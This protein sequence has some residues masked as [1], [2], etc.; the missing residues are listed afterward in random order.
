M[1]IFE[2]MDQAETS[3][4]D[5]GQGVIYFLTRKGEIVYVGKSTIYASPGRIQWHKGKSRK[6]FDSFYI[7]PVLLQNEELFKL[8]AGLICLINPEYNKDKTKVNFLNVQYAMEQIRLKVFNPS[9]YIELAKSRY[10]D[11]MQISKRTLSDDEIGTQIN[12]PKY[13]VPLLKD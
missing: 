12:V 13:I 8:E 5:S 3:V 4:L 7:Y 10:E 11:L 1:N 2:F 9:S 6:D